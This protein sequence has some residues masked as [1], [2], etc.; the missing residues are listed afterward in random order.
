[1]TAEQSGGF[2]ER[3]KAKVAS[4]AE[5]FVRNSLEPGEQIEAVAFGMTMPRLWWSLLSPIL[6]LLVKP[7]ILCL[8]DRRLLAVRGRRLNGRPLE[9]EWAEPHAGVRVERVKKVLN[10][11]LDLRRVSDT[12]ALKLRIGAAWNPEAAEIA[13]ALGG[14]GEPGRN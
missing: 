6:H 1:M 7:Y 12:K 10:T 4:R 2:R 13:A 5:E 11:R 9:L 3:Q 8:T 14:P